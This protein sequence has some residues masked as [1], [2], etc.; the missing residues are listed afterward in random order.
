MKGSKPITRLKSNLTLLPSS[1]HDENEKPRPLFTSPNFVDLEN[2]VVMEQI[3]NIL[4]R[5]DLNEVSGD[6]YENFVILPGLES[7]KAV[8]KALHNAS[9][10]YAELKGCDPELPELLDPPSEEQLKKYLTYEGE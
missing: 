9:E 2:S 10:S 1:N 6:K 8:R 7:M 3:L 5:N 4:P